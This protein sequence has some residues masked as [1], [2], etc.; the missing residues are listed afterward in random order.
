MCAFV[1]VFSFVKE[2]E[3]AVISGNVTRYNRLVGTCPVRLQVS[4]YGTERNEICPLVRFRYRKLS[5]V[6]I[7]IRNHAASCA[8][9]N[10]TNGVFSA[11]RAVVVSVG[12]VARI[13]VGGSGDTS[14]SGKTADC[15][16]DN[17]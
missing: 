4:G 11:Y 14:N 1:R 10:T 17:A 3:R 12:D 7:A 6:H 2:D 9:N 16:V 8:S 13:G 15:A 5:V